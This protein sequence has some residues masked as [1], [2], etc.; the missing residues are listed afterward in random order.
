MSRSVPQGE[1]SVGLTDKSSAGRGGWQYSEV[2]R[3][4]RAIEHSPGELR[5]TT[6]AGMSDG[7]MLMK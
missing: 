7:S 5:S 4:D 3:E 6:K 1:S 2:E